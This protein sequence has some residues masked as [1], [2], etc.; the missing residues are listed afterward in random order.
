MHHPMDADLAYYRDLAARTWGIINPAD[1]PAPRRPQA[2]NYSTAIFLINPACRAI[3]ISYEPDPT[4]PEAAKP[5]GSTIFKSFDPSL[6]KGDFVI[7]PTD[8]RWKMTVGRVEE[9]DV[10]L[11]PDYP[12]QMQWIVGPVDRKPYEDL[13]A[14][15]GDAIAKI[16][17]AEKRR[18]REELASN[19]LK[20]NPDLAAMRIAGEG[21]G[22][23]L[24]AP[25]TPPPAPG[26]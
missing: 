17:S 1:D 6:K 7:I 21:G 23:A 20:D 9:V 18:R 3:L 4:K 26:S 14:Q 12:Q 25:P 15:E 5:G 2:M 8:T 11:D 10:E 19:L 13:M 22:A 16:K 24:E